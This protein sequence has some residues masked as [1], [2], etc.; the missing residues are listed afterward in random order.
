MSEN[1]QPCASLRALLTGAIDY[2][3]LFP[4]ANLALP[5]SVENFGRYLRDPEAWMLG[6]FI[7][8]VGKFSE[9]AALLGPF[10][11]EHPFRVSALGA[12]TETP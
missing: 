6:A 1:G 5:E 3:G 4:P 2:A 12:K 8:P 11:V 10:D 9:A 7:L